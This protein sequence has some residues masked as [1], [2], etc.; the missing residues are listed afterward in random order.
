MCLCGWVSLNGLVGGSARAGAAPSAGLAAPTPARRPSSG[1]SSTSTR[2][3]RRFV[4]RPLHAGGPD[5]TAAKFR[6]RLVLQPLDSGRPESYEFW[7][8]AVKA[9]I[10]A[11]GGGMGIVTV[12]GRDRKTRR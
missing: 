10:V 2:A 7:R 12:R 8:L 3:R 5:K 9:E 11:R 6:E 1:P 4:E